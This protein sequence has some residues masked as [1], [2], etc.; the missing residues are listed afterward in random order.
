MVDN[1]NVS[2]LNYY[3]QIKFDGNSCNKS[4]CDAMWY[5]NGLLNRIEKNVYLNEQSEQ[6]KV[7][8][9]ALK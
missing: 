2:L 9:L 4:A 8:L 5:S 7:K 1:D 3:K 6:I